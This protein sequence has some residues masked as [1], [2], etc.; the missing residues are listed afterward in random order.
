MKINM[1]A[2]KD[3]FF[4]QQNTGEQNV[5]SATLA[6]WLA[7]MYVECVIWYCTDSVHGHYWWYDILA[8]WWYTWRF[9]L[10]IFS[11]RVNLSPRLGGT[12][13]GQSTPTPTTVLSFT[14]IPPTAAERCK[15]SQQ[16]WNRVMNWTWTCVSSTVTFLIRLQGPNDSL[17]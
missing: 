8:Y 17:H 11:M 3:Y 4:Y 16:V 1:K 12:H 7:R 2:S 14:F 15:V 13:S 6:E 10:E 9:F 5:S